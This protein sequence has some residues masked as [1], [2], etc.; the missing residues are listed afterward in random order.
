MEKK[1]AQDFI[2]NI[3]QSKFDSEQFELL[4]R[5]LLNN[6][7]TRDNTYQG[8]SLWEAYRDHISQ[9]RRIGKYIDL[10]WRC[11]RYP[12]CRNQITFKA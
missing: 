5:N 12:Y 9:Y 7:E 4:I 3:F 8:G 10:K 11:L 1:Q 2:N 6:F